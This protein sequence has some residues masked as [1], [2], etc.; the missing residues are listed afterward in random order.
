[1][2]QRMDVAP[3]CRWKNF[4]EWVLIGMSCR[5]NA[6]R[7]TSKSRQDWSWIDTSF[8]LLVE[9]MEKMPK[10]NQK[11]HVS[12]DLFGIYELI[13]WISTFKEVPIPTAHLHPQQ[14]FQPVVL[15]TCEAA[16]R[17]GICQNRLWNLAIGSTRE[18][19]DLPALIALAKKSP[20]VTSYI[21]HKEPEARGPALDHDVCTSEFCKFSDINST[22]VKQLHKCK[23]R[24]C[25]EFV[26]FPTSEFKRSS[27]QYT[28][29]LER[30][31]N[32]KEIPR[33]VPGRY[34]AISHVWSDGTG[35]G[36][37]E[38]GRVN[39]CLFEFFTLISEKMG[40]KAIWWDTISIP[41]ERK[42][43]AKAINRMHENYEQA[44]HTIVHDEYLVQFPWADD[45]SP[46]LALVLSPWFTRGWTA[47]ELI[48]SNKDTVWV[49]FRDPNDPQKHVIKNLEAEILASHPFECSLGHLVASSIVKRLRDQRIRS[50]TDLMAVLRTRST[51]WR[52]DRMI[53]AGLLTGHQVETSI[54]DLQ[55]QLTRDILLCFV[56]IEAE[57]LLH[58]LTPMVQ[59]G[60]F[61]WCPLTIFDGHAPLERAVS[62]MFVSNKLY[63]DEQGAVSG[64]WKFHTLK[65][66]DLDKLRPHSFH[67]SNDYRIRVALRNW[68]RCLLLR[69]LYS[70]RR[71][72]PALLVTVIEIGEWHINE[73]DKRSVVDCQY[74]GSV[75]EEL[76]WPSTVQKISIRLG[77]NTKDP[78][79]SAQAVLSNYDWKQDAPSPLNETFWI[80][81]KN[82]I[83][84]KRMRSIKEKRHLGEIEF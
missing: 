60:G 68:Q 75:Y 40:C 26:L 69:P 8:E 72:S 46:C 29:W 9:H 13:Y 58:G 74:I 61:S 32:P 12:V 39:R 10:A 78:R 63:I 45:G 67:I 27:E 28:W 11:I 24:N 7:L 50:L 21:K 77:I 82:E 79:E 73:D 65:K 23:T 38:Q 1:M 34:V 41:I 14:V 47:L 80:V 83:S 20:Q 30:N 64:A 51:S 81:E 71:P 49:L 5:L 66:Q 59:K 31:N 56:D 4:R 62:D 18:Q 6:F 22:S 36:V 55:S 70:D 2:K 37:Q 84:K 35:I 53:I 43:R 57:F 52:R 15:E 25:N 16:Q 76:A 48:K 44:A 17:L 33:I 19:D 42:A 3:A 54:G